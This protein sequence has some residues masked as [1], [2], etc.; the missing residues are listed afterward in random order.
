MCQ[1]GMTTGLPMYIRKS[2]SLSVYF[3]MLYAHLHEVRGCPC[4]VSAS[5][6]WND[7]CCVH[8]SR[9]LFGTT[10]PRESELLSLFL[11][12]LCKR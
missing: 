2:E 1:C 12:R 3:A 5:S 7:S 6:I 11:G 9:L 10:A 4:V 8:A